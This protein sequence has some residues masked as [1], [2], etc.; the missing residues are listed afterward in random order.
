MGPGLVLC[1]ES[2]YHEICVMENND[3]ITAP[4]V[5]GFISFY[6]AWQKIY[7]KSLKDFYEFMTTPSPDRSEFMNSYRNST[8]CDLEKDTAVITLKQNR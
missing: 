8:I 4:Q 2:Q 1:Y 6:A 3:I 5:D 7:S